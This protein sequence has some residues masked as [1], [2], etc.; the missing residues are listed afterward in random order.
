MNVKHSAAALKPLTYHP[1]GKW[2]IISLLFA[3]VFFF[4]QF[5]APGL[6]AII[7]A[8]V[9]WPVYRELLRMTGG[10]SISSATIAI[11][12]ITL[13]I[14]LPV[15]WLGHYL[16]FEFH[17]LSNWLVQLNRYGSATPEWIKNLPL[18]GHQLNGLW[19]E[20]LGKENGLNELLQLAGLQRV[21]S[22]ANYILSLG[23]QFASIGF[24]LLFIL[25][26]LFFLYKDGKKLQSNL[27]KV[28]HIMFLDR[29]ERISGVVPIM[30]RSTVT[31]MV[32]IAIGEGIVFGL[33]YWMV[34][35]PSSTAL[36]LGIMTGIFA[37]IPG[38]APLSMTMVSLYL[39]G[40]GL[41][42]QGIILFSW[43]TCQLFIVDKTIRPRLVGGPAKLP[44]LPTFFGLV[45]GLQTMG[46]L[47]LFIGPVL[48]A[49]L[50]VIWREWVHDEEHVKMEE[51][52]VGLRKGTQKKTT[53]RRFM[54][55]KRPNA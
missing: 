46:L 31:G 55:R 49:L 26:I 52:I 24:H 11:I 45:G 18:V 12:I 4:H 34:G 40:S 21:T 48:M 13:L 47:G 1:V 6:A 29:W 43:G 44:F 38:G 16:L 19:L 30:I 14:V 36:T 20:Y 28:G 27:A 15:F 17:G 42:T 33:V 7:I 2:L 25:I 39:V 9:T 35:I 41:V 10:R 50:L 3:G 54:Q 22:F 51:K 8:V 23:K 32:I 37:L 5:F 53:L